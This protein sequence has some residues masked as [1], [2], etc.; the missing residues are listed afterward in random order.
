M[1][2]KGVL[3]R[4][5]REASHPHRGSRQTGRD[6]ALSAAMATA[7]FGTIRGDGGG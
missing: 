6:D 2:K 4:A 5:S 7:T 3:P 1:Q